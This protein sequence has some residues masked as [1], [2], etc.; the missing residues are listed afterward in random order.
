MRAPRAQLVDEAGLP[1]AGLAGDQHH[2]RAAALGRP[3]QLGQARALGAAADEHRGGS[4]ALFLDGRPWEQ[5]LVELP[6]G[7]GGLDAEL[8]PER[9]RARVVGAQRA[10]PVAALV[11]QAHEQAVGGLA[12]RVVAHEPLG[13]HDRPRGVALLR[14]PPGEPVQRVEVALAQAL[15]LLEQPLVVGALEQVAGVGVDRLAQGVEV[16]VARPRQRVLEHGDVE[17]Q[18]RVRASAACVP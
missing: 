12:Q 2:L 15:A 1:D 6:R 7:R 10:R 18:R 16:V 14:Q 9:R 5:R 17:P 11:V 3:P 13:V 8:A 4:A